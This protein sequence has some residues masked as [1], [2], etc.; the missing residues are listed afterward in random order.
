MSDVMLFG[1]L[2]MPYEM[3]MADE[4]SR[5]QFY[6]RVQEAATMLRQQALE[7]KENQ[8]TI[9]GDAKLI[10]LLYQKVSEQQQRITELESKNE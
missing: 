3:A 7:L 5:F 10:Q 6:Q 9:D 4:L 2:N 1:V 8:R